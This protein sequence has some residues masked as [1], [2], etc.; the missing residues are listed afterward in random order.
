V[1]LWVEDGAQGGQTYVPVPFYLSSA[2]YGLHIDTDVR[3]V[4]RMAVPDDPGVV[5]IRNAASLNLTVVAGRTPKEI[6]SRYA[7]IAGRPEVPP[8][9]VFGPWKSRDWQ[10]ADQVGIRK[11]VEMQRELGPS[12][13]VKLL[14][15]RW[16]AA[17]HTFAFD[18]KKFPDP[19][20]M[21]DH[22][23]AYG[24]PH[25]YCFGAELLVA[26]V[27]YG[28]SR[29]RL[30]YLPVGEWRGFWSGELLRVGRVV[31][32]RA[33]VESIPVFARA[34]AIIPRLDPSPDTLLPATR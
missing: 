17:Y 24:S 8:E 25:Q 27:Y 7:A 3:C 34:G 33:G 29:T 12:A 10:T 23:H 32:R 28:F 11:D 13:T 2:G 5:S 26:P 20:G 15:A 22:I 14:D 21:I 1:D 18:P 4:A 31:R 19:R 9:W 6:L 16:E 30:V